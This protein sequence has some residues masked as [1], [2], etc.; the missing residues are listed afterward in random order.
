M[1]FVPSAC[2]VISKQIQ[3]RNT[4]THRPAPP[5][6]SASRPALCLT[7]QLSCATGLRSFEVKGG[8]SGNIWDGVRAPARLIPPVSSRHQFPIY[9]SRS[10]ADWLDGFEANRPA[11][12][13]SG[14]SE[15]QRPGAGTGSGWFQQETN[16]KAVGGRS[17]STVQIAQ[18]WR[19]VSPV[20]MSQR[21]SG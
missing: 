17:F 21:A 20:L 4:K 18:Q 5:P 14:S 1:A 2:Q 13:Q 3:F 6:T 11:T 16:H 9:R 15:P 7:L 8:T 19:K 12:E 10:E